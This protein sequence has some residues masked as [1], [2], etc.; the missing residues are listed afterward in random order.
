MTGAPPGTKAAAGNNH[1]DHADAEVAK[2]AVA[3]QLA[4]TVRGP[5]ADIGTV[6]HIWREKS[7]SDCLDRIWPGMSDDV[8]HSVVEELA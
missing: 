1:Q 3:V 6:W 8:F 7:G 4:V 5:G 2:R